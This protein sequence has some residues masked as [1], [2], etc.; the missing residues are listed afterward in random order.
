M[1]PY[2][3]H[4]IDVINCSLEN[5]A[6]CKTHCCSWFKVKADR[7]PSVRLKDIPDV[8]CTDRIT[9]AAY[10]CIEEDNFTLF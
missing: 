10:G 6:Y 2:M 9:V 5:K 3:S 4:I 1:L 7:L 8:H